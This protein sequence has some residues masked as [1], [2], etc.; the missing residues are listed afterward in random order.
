[1]VGQARPATRPLEQP[2]DHGG[3]GVHA[4]RVEDRAQLRLDGGDRGGAG[5]VEAD[6]RL[7]TVV[8]Q[9]PPQDGGVQRRVPPDPEV[10]QLDGEPHGPV[11]PLVRF[12]GIHARRV[13]PTRSVMQH[14]Q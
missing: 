8:G 9:E 7:L 13:G 12:A 6:R 10:H 4:W 14:W 3:G 1:M 11:R 5:L 2:V